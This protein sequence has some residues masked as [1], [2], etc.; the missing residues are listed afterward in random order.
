VSAFRPP[1]RDGCAVLSAVSANW[2]ESDTPKNPCAF[3]GMVIH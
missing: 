1:Q 2:T 3:R